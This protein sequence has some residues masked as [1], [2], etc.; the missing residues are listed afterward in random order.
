MDWHGPAS[1]IIGQASIRGSNAAAV[2]D[3]RLR[4]RASRHPSVYRV[5]DWDESSPCIT[6]TMFGS[7]APAVGDIRVNLGDNTHKNLYRLVDWGQPAHTVTGA[8][9]PAGGAASVAD[10]RLGC[11]P[12]SGSY[13]VQD[14]Y[15]PG[16]TITGSADIHQGTAAVGDIRIPELYDQPDPPPIIISPWETW[17]RPLT[18]YEMAILQGFPTHLPD[19]RPF[20][21]TGKSDARWRK[22][23][24]DAVPP[25]SAEVWAGL[26][27]RALLLSLADSWELSPT[28]IWVVPGEI[29]DEE[30]S[31]EYM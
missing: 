11:F 6:G 31:M 30:V 12:R 19:G 20:Q 24:G 21:L 3:I 13:G 28:A 16:K 7:G 26:I 27:L 22:R 4:D 25:P 1:T 5:V 23:I 14:W 9:R 8:T 18:T 29:I 2:A 17:N 10:I 15:A